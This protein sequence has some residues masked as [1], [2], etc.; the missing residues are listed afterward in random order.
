MLQQVSEFPSF[1]RLNTILLYPY[2]A[3][4]HLIIHQWTRALPPYCSYCEQQCD[5]HERTNTVC[6]SMPFLA[7]LQRLELLARWQVALV[8][9]GTLALSDLERKRSLLCR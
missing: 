6:P 2:T 1:L 5:E 4:C 8:R 7:S 9:V 3:F